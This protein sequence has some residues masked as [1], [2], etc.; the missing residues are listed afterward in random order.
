[1]KR[2]LRS[3][4]WRIPVEQEVSEDKD[5]PEVAG[6]LSSWHDHQD[7]CW[8]GSQVTGRIDANGNCARG[9]FRPTAPMLHVWVTEHEC[10]PF[11]GIEGAHGAG[12]DHDEH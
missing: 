8:E 5:R 12:C 3:W 2:S 4:L 6:E 1:M 11:A 9:V 7:L 10:G